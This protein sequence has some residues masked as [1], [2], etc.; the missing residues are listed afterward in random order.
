M[1]SLQTGERC[2]TSSKSFFVLANRG[3]LDLASSSRDL[4]A[5]GVMIARQYQVG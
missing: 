2:F 1:A 5:D 3:D 4:G